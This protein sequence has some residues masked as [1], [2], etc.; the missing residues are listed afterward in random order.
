MLFNLYIDQLIVKLH[1]YWVACEWRLMGKCNPYAATHGL[2]HNLKKRE[3][4][5]LKAENKYYSIPHITLQ[6]VLLNKVTQVKYL[7]DWFA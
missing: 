3:Q 4:M 5:L 7:G 2:R 6:G 1:E